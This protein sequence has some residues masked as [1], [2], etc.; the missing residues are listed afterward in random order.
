MTLIWGRT[1]RVFGYLPRGVT[2]TS[3]YLVHVTKSYIKW[4]LNTNLH[5]LLI[6]Y[7]LI[8][9]LQAWSGKHLP[10]IFGVSVTDCS[11]NKVSVHFLGPYY[12]KGNSDRFSGKLLSA[13]LKISVSMETLAMPTEKNS[14]A[15]IKVSLI[16]RQQ[17]DCLAP[18][19]LLMFDKGFFHK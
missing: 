12:F 3:D 4:V 8:P 9:N 14:Y 6:L 2:F 1:G 18:M 19:D 11:I 10:L 16:S 5:I 17:F 7:P 13:T 15:L